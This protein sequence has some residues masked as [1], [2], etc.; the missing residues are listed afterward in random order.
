MELKESQQFRK[1]ERITSKLLINR[2][3]DGE[4]TTSIVVFPFRVVSMKIPKKEVPV[5][6]LI[7]VPKKRFHNAVDRNRMKRLTREAYRKQ[8]H[9]LW[10]TMEEADES[11]AIAFIYISSNLSSY[12]TVYKS[13]NKALTRLAKGE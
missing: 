9:I 11:L 13:M 5:S 3:F 6:V 1:A 7:S 2:L 4:G 12:Q 8:K 10:Q